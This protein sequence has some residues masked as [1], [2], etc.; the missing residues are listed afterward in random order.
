MSVSERPV[1]LVTELMH[2][3]GIER[4]EVFARVIRTAAP[5]EASILELAPQFRGVIV[6]VAPIT[7]AVIDAAP[8]LRLI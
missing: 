7:A 2:P 1:V 5:D 4:L 8:R 3:A 6:R